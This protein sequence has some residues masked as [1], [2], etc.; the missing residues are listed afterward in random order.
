[1]RT[2]LLSCSLLITGLTALNPTGETMIQNDDFWLRP[3]NAVDRGKPYTYIEFRT[4]QYGEP[5]SIEITGIWG[6][7]PVEQLTESAWQAVLR[8]SFISLAPSLSLVI[9]QGVSSRKEG[10]EEVRFGGGPNSPDPLGSTV[11]R[12]EREYVD[13]VVNCE[14]KRI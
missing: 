5:N 11:T 7:C 3:T 1:L 14:R 8:R 9:S 6:R 12:C 13:L 4:P 10:D 2:G